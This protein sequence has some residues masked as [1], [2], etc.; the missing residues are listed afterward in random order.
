MVKRTEHIGTFLHN[1]MGIS[2]RGISPM[3]DCS[4]IRL[5][6]IFFLRSIAESLEGQTVGRRG[7]S[8]NVAAPHGFAPCGAVLIDS[9]PSTLQLRP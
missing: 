3:C 8:Q 5:Q 7:D 4:S 1:E 6:K 2:L 9:C